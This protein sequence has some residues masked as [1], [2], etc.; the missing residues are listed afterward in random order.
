MKRNLI[1]KVASLVLVA[2]ILAIGLV[3]AGS[4]TK[5]LASSFVTERPSISYQAD[6][7]QCDSNGGFWYKVGCYGSQL[8]KEAKEDAKKIGSEVKEYLK[9]A[10]TE[11]KDG[12]ADA[13]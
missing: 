5:V 6:G 9:E 7:E 13:Q 11:L 4:T 1:G 2:S 10:V 12:I 3:V 8:L